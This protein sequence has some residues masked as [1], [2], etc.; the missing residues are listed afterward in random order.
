YNAADITPENLKQYD[1][2]FLDSTTGCFLD[3]PGDKAATDARRAALLSFVRG[4]KGLAGVHAA[5]D[6][7]HSNCSGGRGG[8]PAGPAPAA[9]GAPAGRGGRGGGPAGQLAGQIVTQADKN[10][11][12]KLSLVELG[13]VADAW[14][15]K[16]DTEKAGRV[17]QA[18]F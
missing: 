17:S 6:S 2:L 1:A 10:G 8:A 18:D 3:D 15:E 5:T 12:Q 13:A 14:F 16:L 9:A 7:Y 11:D 4:G